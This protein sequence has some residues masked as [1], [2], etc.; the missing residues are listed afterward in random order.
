MT[1]DPA[2]GAARDGLTRLLAGRPERYALTSATLDDGRR[3]DLVV[4]DG[5][6]EELLSVGSASCPEGVDLDGALV[7]PR[8]V[9]GHVHL[10]KTL[11]GAPWLPHKAGG[12][13]RERIAI[14][15]SGREEV[16]VPVAARA[17]ALLAQLAATGTGLV[18]SH[19]DID[20]DVGLAHLEA[21]LE[22]R[23]RWAGAVDIE[24]VAFPQSGIV[25][26][27]GVGGLLEEALRAGAEVVGGL[28]PIGFDRDLH[29]HLDVVFGLAERHGARVDIHLHDDGPTGL[30]ELREIAAR[31]RRA[32]LGGRTVVSHA[33]CLGTASADEVQR[34]AE[35]LASAGVAI[36][37]NGPVGCVP[38]VLQL[39]AAGVTVFCG[40]DNIRDAWWP[41]GNG[42]QLERATIVAY[43]SGWR[44]DE[45]LATAYELIG[46]AAAAAL[47]RPRHALEP[48]APADLVVVAARGVPEAVAAHPERLAVIVG[49]RSVDQVL[50]SG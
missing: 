23:A 17:E 30:L 1:T 13:V 7:V 43:Q 10:D 4:G 16:G 18:R 22:V 8:L 44:T 32:D 6:I 15:R 35:D 12:S 19:V 34:V 11:A 2:L 28:D 14:E 38:P 36:M 27:P 20:P 48:G 41:F 5:R 29:G 50:P 45:E 46:C 9:D 42:D 37:T 24:F 25:A 31:T 39:R 3:V 49:G 33:Y 21:L 40:S 26:A 47:G